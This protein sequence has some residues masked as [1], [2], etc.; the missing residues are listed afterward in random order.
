MSIEKKRRELE[1]SSYRPKRLAEKRDLKNKELIY[2]FYQKIK[3]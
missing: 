3:F 1:E 2:D